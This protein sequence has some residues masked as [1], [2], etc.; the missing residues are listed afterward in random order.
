MENAGMDRGSVYLSVHS[1]GVEERMAVATNGKR[2]SWAL[3]A[4]AG[5]HL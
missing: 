3:E 1:S 4:Y 5:N 2:R